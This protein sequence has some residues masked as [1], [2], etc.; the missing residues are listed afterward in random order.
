MYESE[1]F[2]RDVQQYGLGDIVQSRSERVA[3]ASTRAQAT[4]IAKPYAGYLVTRHLNFRLI[5]SVE[6]VADR[7]VFVWLRVLTRGGDEYGRFPN[8]AQNQLPSILDRS[9]LHAWFDE[10][11]EAEIEAARPVP[12]PDE[13]MPWLEPI[14]P[15]FSGEDWEDE[16]V[17][18]TMQWVSSMGS[19][20]Q[21]RWR[22]VHRMVARNLET[23]REPSENVV[24]WY[25]D[26]GV[27]VVAQCT[28]HKALFLLAVLHPGQSLAD[29]GVRFVPLGAEAL[30]YARRAYP[31]WLLADEE[32]WFDIQK[33]SAH[34]LALSPEE[35]RLLRRVAG[36]TASGSE[37]PMFI[38]GQAGSGKSTMLAYVFAG[39]CKQKHL[40]GADGRPVFITYNANLLEKARTTAR[41]ILDAHPD[42]GRPF[43]AVS[44]NGLFVSWRD[45]LLALLPDEQREGFAADRR[46]DYHDFT[47]AWMGA[48]SKLPRLQVGRGE[49]SAETVWYAIRSLIKGSDFAGDLH[50]DDYV[51]ELTRDERTFSVATYREIYDRFYLPWYAAALRDGDL[52]DDQ[53]LTRAAL[54]ALDERSEP[55]DVAAL[56][57]DEAQD[58]T[59][60]ELRLITRTTAYCDYQ[61]PR[62]GNRTRP[63]V[64]FAGDPLQ[65][66]SPTGFRWGA[67]KASMF[68]EFQGLFGPEAPQPVFEELLNN[69]RS[70]E[71]IVRL[72]NTIQL[73]RA[74]LFSIPDV[75]PQGAW[76]PTSDVGV[77]EKFILEELDE[78]QFMR[79]ASDTV[80]VVPCEEG[81]EIRFVQNDPTL[82]KMY[83]NA[84][85]KEPPTWVF[86][87]AGIKG[88]EYDKVVLYKF[89]EAA[90][91]VRWSPETRE[92]ERDLQAEYFFNKLY[93]AATRATQNV[94]VADSLAGDAAL[95]TR[96]ERRAVD[97]LLRLAIARGVSEFGE[98]H[99][100]T[101]EA[102][103]AD[104]EGVQE[105]N[106]RENAV[107]T[108]D[109][110]YD[111]RSSRK[112]RQAASFFRRANE[113]READECE[114]WAL[115][116]DGELLEAG[117]MFARAMRPGE[118]W[119]CLWDHRAWSDLSTLA[120]QRPEVSPLELAVVR[121]MVTQARVFDDVR[122]FAEEIS[123]THGAI[124]TDASWNE[125]VAAFCRE[126]LQLGLDRSPDEVAP[127]L[128][129]LEHLFESGFQ[130]AGVVAARVCSALGN[131][132]RA[133]ELLGLLR[134]PT[135]PDRA[136]LYREVL[137]LPKAL[138]HL[139]EA[140]LSRDVRDA[141][142]EA[143]RPS[144]KEWMTWVEPTL[145]G[146]QFIAER[147]ALLLEGGKV[148]DAA[149][150]FLQNG[151]WGDSDEYVALALRI[152]VAFAAVGLHDEAA[153]FIARV[154]DLRLGRLSKE[155]M[156]TALVVELAG[157]FESAQWPALD[158]E[159]RDS[160]RRTA[161]EVYKNVM[162]NTLKPED[163][164]AFGAFFEVARQF[165]KARR[166]YERSSR[167]RDSQLSDYCRRRF[168]ACCTEALNDRGLNSSD[169]GRLQEEQHARATDWR[170]SV[171]QRA[172]VRMARLRKGGA[173]TTT[174]PS[175]ASGEIGGVKWAY[176]SA[177]H[178]LVIDVD[179]ESRDVLTKARISTLGAEHKVRGGSIASTAT[180]VVLTAGDSFRVDITLEAE[181]RLIVEVDGAR[182]GEVV[183][184]RIM[185]DA[186]S[187][188]AGEDDGA[189]SPTGRTGGRNRGR[190]GR[191]S[192]RSVGDRKPKPVGKAAGQLSPRRL[193]GELGV[194]V[195]EVLAA[196]EEIGF[197]QRAENDR[198][199]ATEQIALRAY[200]AKKKAE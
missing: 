78:S 58:F 57:I 166:V 51:E 19:L 184:Q 178:E 104:L 145:S 143:G 121:Y 154:S 176:S 48:K 139:L 130:E 17:Y 67:V 117:R 66:L 50:P 111:T 118:A 81:G 6:Q 119:R 141:W 173:A 131:R 20:D 71:P 127:V 28:E 116:F 128:G 5:A 126:A 59:R 95:W 93:V 190:G 34:N 120:A 167:S 16:I 198:L 72:A 155:V 9:A 32:M 191:D 157:Y 124:K 31:I 10:M 56:V 38:N 13:L 18:E 137:G 115:R 52:W 15:I 63:P 14:R 87:A 101:V 168:L 89:G 100:G 159:Q 54:V 69:Y 134:G 73:W 189:P 98:E 21:Y 4:R 30:R 138:P 179:D 41:R 82:S 164:P 22:E 151:S 200:F 147:L 1:Q 160:L 132:M 102:G 65:T 79:F 180:G 35:Q 75:H 140:G 94:Y 170:L 36:Q 91:S 68:E 135:N 23:L 144:S 83:P 70:A 26:D 194:P 183:V 27:G 11:R 109:Y 64:V 114:A 74:V 136:R 199:P 193:S 40:T 62:T 60:R 161:D 182:A 197:G 150:A 149:D 192:N 165:A 185:S 37:L 177:E 44:L 196:L 39:L 125:A 146:P 96:L 24:T 122:R 153:Q 175:Q 29:A 47:L 77:P 123:S 90:T 84:S 49:H 12:L 99:L 129:A 42:S 85:E 171:D 108:R 7:E 106:P 172:H 80:M 3:H 187:Q 105:K 112:M 163:V 181:I 152:I 156:F 61:I 45:Y 188:S 92:S 86:S 158:V 33:G 162:I 97:D 25:S 174:V 88:L 169:R 110:A 113:R 133:I 103:A 55:N 8:Y 148:E 46:V 195:G 142:V 76:S 186:A 53:D 107:R 2:K 43:G